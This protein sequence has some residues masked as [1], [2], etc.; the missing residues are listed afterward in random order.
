VMMEARR[1]MCAARFIRTGSRARVYRKVEDKRVRLSADG[2]HENHLTDI[3]VV[4]H[5]HSVGLVLVYTVWVSREV[6][7]RAL[8]PRRVPDLSDLLEDSDAPRREQRPRWALHEDVLQVEEQHPAR[9]HA[10]EAQEAA[11]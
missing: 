2:D 6:C 9:S 7:V 5:D 4:R 1:R 11:E 8:I 3:V 10:G